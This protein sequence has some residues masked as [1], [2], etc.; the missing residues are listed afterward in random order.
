[1]AF[2]V[3][4]AVAL[5]VTFAAYGPALRAEF[6]SDDTNAIVENEWVVGDLDPVGIFRNQSWWGAGRADSAGYRPGATLSFALSR[7]TAGN[8]PA[9]Y[10]IANYVLNALCAALLFSLARLLGL[11][12]VAAGA[13]ALLFAVLPIHSEAVIWIVGRAE[14][15]A[16]LGFLVATI[17]ALVHRQSGSVAALPV[18]G[19]AVLVGLTFKENTITAL[20]MPVVFLLAL[21]R[22]GD[23]TRRTGAAL[24]AMIAGAVVYTLL[25][26]TTLGPVGDWQGGSLLDNPLSVVDAGTRFLGALAVLGRYVWLT[27]W[28][29]SLSIDYSWNALGVGPGF[30]A[31][32][33]SVVALLFL[34]A[35]VW[36][37]WKGPG[38][39]DVVAVGLGLAAAS[40][41]I[42]SNTVFVLGT[43][44]GERLFFLPTAGICL[45]LAAMA[46]PMLTATPA[47]RRRGPSAKRSPYA[48][49]SAVGVAVLLVACVGLDRA[50]SADWLTAVSLF[51]SAA[52]VV[53]QSARAHMELALAYGKSGRIDES[54][55]HSARAL[56]IK[57]DYAAA[58]YNH[59]NVL[60]RA[61]RY[62]EAIAAYQRTLEIEPKFT[63]AWH[64]LALTHKIR[65][66]TGEW[67]DA[68]Q[69]AV[70]SSPTSNLL[71]NELGEAL[72][73]AQRYDQAIAVYDAL[74]AD[75]STIAAPFYNRG[76]ARHHLGGCPA[77]IDD[78]LLA[79]KA[80]D[81]PAPVFATAAGCLR[82]LGRNAD[83]DAVEQAAKVANRGTRR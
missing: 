18:A 63:R 21:G 46:E 47:R 66:R 14:L 8:E 37:I 61:S 68:M 31:N 65:G 16:A 74:I 11:A 40:Y 15:G 83:A 81:A 60:V 1:M 43:M 69:G 49:A 58:A 2:G 71:R 24:A 77:A 34:A 54:S 23:S 45:A 78:Y 64:N 22:D 36:A 50:R 29:T 76:I 27:F 19:A 48:V 75:G 7:V 56:E 26:A 39:R 30:V 67:A 4:T 38:R 59:G 33:D 25:R 6:V 52:E 57:P 80:S 10:R 9:G 3:A 32:G 41:S 35:C 12:P 20:A 28:P 17:A 13:A 62:E 79:T 72:L 82:Q 51:E 55:A 5:V 42:V 73:A 53:P 70:D 44:L